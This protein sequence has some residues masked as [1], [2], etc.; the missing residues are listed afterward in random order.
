MGDD[1]FT[2]ALVSGKKE[3]ETDVHSL[4]RVKLGRN[5][6]QSRDA[7]KT[8]IY[9]WVLGASAPKTA[10]V[11]ECSVSEAVIARQN[12]VDGYPGLKKVKEELV[13]TDQSK[14]YFVGLD[15]RKVTVSYTHLTLPTKRI[16]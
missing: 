12:F 14:G 10:K 5:I 3:N 11:L 1:S 15:G 6:C 4:N 7:A 9:S 8:F 2:T 13:P 16:V